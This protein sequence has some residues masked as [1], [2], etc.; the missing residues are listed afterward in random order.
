VSQIIGLA[1]LSM[2]AG[3]TKRPRASF[4]ESISARRDI[5]IKPKVQQPEGR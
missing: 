5:D 4:V 2:S 3:G 1:P